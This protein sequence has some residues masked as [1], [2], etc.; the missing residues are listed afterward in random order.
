VEWLE[1]LAMLFDRGE[2]I[3][4]L[5]AGENTASVSFEQRP[6]FFSDEVS[7]ALQQ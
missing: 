5:P 6:A 1:H 2:L 3:Q 4:D 7:A